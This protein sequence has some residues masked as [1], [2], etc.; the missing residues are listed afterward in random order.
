M[1]DDPFNFCRDFGAVFIDFFKERKCYLV[2]LMV[3]MTVSAA[4]WSICDH[5]NCWLYHPASFLLEMLWRTK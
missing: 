4:Y 1:L 5:L 2:F 3:L